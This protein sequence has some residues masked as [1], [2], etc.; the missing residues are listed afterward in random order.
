MG[1]RDKN[2][3]STKKK[4]GGKLQQSPVSPP[5]QEAPMFRFDGDTNRQ[6]EP[7]QSVVDDT[8]APIFRFG[9]V[10]EDAQTKSDVGV[11]VK[12]SEEERP[13]LRFNIGDRVYCNFGRDGWESGTIAMRHCKRDDGRYHPYYVQL[14]KGGFVF[15]P[16]DKDKTIKKSDE[17]MHPTNLRYIVGDRV[18]CRIHNGTTEEWVS[19]TVILRNG[20]LKSFKE[21]N[22]TYKLKSNKEISLDIVPY[23]VRLDG[24]GV[25]AVPID[26][27]NYIKQTI[28]PAKLKVFKVGSRVDICLDKAKDEWASGTVSHFS[29]TG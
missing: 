6:P 26:N 27:D 21:Q 23:N 19:G 4:R 3:A 15:V 12:A 8:A 1:R 13:E 24:G 5:Q 2:R 22:T 7:V 25:A 11:G 29:Q 20:N 18:D 16:Y 9:A 28:D 14:D 17:K 10:P